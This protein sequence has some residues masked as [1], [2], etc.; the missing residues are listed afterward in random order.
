[1]ENSKFYGYLKNP[2]LYGPD[3]KSVKVLETHISFV[4]LTGEYAYKIKKPVNFGFLNFSSLEKRK[5]FCEKEIMLNK[6]LSPEIYLQV[7]AITKKNDHL[8]INGK[9]ETIEYAVK[10]KEFPQEHIMKNLLRRE[11]IT[12]KKIEEI[13]QILVNFYKKAKNSRYIDKFGTVEKI[14]Q[15]IDEN[16]DQTRQMINSVISKKK[17][18][19]IKRANVT[20]LSSKK[21]IFEKRIKEKKIRDC[22]G[23]LH[24]GNIVISD[25]IYI[26]DCIEF[27][28]RFRYSDVAAD[29]A[30]LAMD[31]DFLNR[32]YLSSYLVEKYIEYSNDEDILDIINFYKCYRAY[33]RGK[34]AGF[35]LN[36]CDEGQREKIIKEAKRYFDLSYYYANLLLKDNSIDKKTKMFITCG[37]TGTGKSVV[38]GKLAIDYSAKI[39]STD[40]LR[41]EIANLD[42]Y[43]RVY[44]KYGEGLYSPEKINFVYKKA[45]K[46]AENCLSKN[47]NCIID[48]TFQKKKHRD[49]AYRLAK[50]KN[51]N[52]LIVECVSSEKEVKE[53]L[54]KRAENQR[55][56]SD[57]R[58][59][60]YLE[61]RKVFEPLSKDEKFIRFDTS[62]SYYRYREKILKKI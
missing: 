7:V 51:A 10:M 16:F 61:Q 12:K 13:C 59:E 53:R 37:L 22:H 49:M 5:Y 17:F 15:N 62:K 50:D 32:P 3:V 56:I 8:E 23:D 14:S 25:K 31:L 28:E 27:N 9:G 24:T 33:V 6:R 36:E 26:F 34:V 39:I 18:E 44:E 60:I 52:F 30:F 45:I 21:D 57:G 19:F 35:K 58:W 29:I 54:R 20:F 38:A 42:K 47:K 40:I 46:M 55:S 43:T 2:A 41:K 4:I 11:K 1:M 48:A